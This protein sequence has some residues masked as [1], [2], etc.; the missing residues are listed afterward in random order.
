[1][2]EAVEV[3]SRNPYTRGEVRVYRL[4]PPF[5]GHDEV[6]VSAIELRGRFYEETAQGLNSETVIFPS[7]HGRISELLHLAMVP[8]ISHEDALAQIG[9]R[10]ATTEEVQ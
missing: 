9:Y 4:N 3:E 7:K 5:D 10:V 1:M 8:Y 2:Y 6:A